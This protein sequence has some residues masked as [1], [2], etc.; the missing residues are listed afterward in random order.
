MVYG[1]RALCCACEDQQPPCE[2]FCCQELGT[3]GNEN[4]R[5]TIGGIAGGCPCTSANRNYDFTLNRAQDACFASPLGVIGGHLANCFDGPWDFSATFGTFEGGCAGAQPFSLDIF[6]TPAGK[7]CKIW[8]HTDIN[9]DLDFVELEIAQQCP[10][11]FSGLTF[12][13]TKL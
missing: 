6:N 8:V 7:R 3:G 2:P 11:N 4:W 5:V 13:V 12:S 1:P 9:C 10:C